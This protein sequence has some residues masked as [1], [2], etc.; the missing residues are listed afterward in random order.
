MN[1]NLQKL[2]NNSEEIEIII[3]LEYMAHIDEN[4]NSP[5]SLS[6]WANQLISSHKIGAKEA[7]KLLV[8]VKLL[9]EFYDAVFEASNLDKSKFLHYF[10]SITLGENSFENVS[11]ASIVALYTPQ[12][13][14]ILNCDKDTALYSSIYHSILQNTSDFLDF[15]LKNKRP[16]NSQEEFLSELE[17]SEIDDAIKWKIYQLVK[18]HDTYKTEIIQMINIVKEVYTKKSDMIATMVESYAREID[19]LLLN[20]TEEEFI[21]HFHMSFEKNNNIKIYFSL[22]AFNAISLVK[23]YTSQDDHIMLIGIFFVYCSNIVKYTPSQ[24]KLSAT[25]KCLGESRKFEIIISLINSPCNGKELSNRLGITPATISH[26]ITQ[27]VKT[28]VVTLKHA[29]S[30]NVMYHVNRE[31][32]SIHM[33]TL[34]DIFEQ[35]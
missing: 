14:A 17:K 34:K 6:V 7:E 25:L 32:L 12:F 13:M 26:H 27:L 24:E 23:P 28:G 19:E 2:H 31:M 8:D 15:D 10:N 30:P 21:E 33:Q 3:Y 29:D 35:E 11:I 1:L 5:N 9:Q 22:S 18:N 16:I 4:E 20:S